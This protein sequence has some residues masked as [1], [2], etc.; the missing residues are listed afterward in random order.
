MLRNLLK[1]TNN[2]QASRYLK[3]HKCAAGENKHLYYLAAKDK[4]FYSVPDGGGGAAADEC[5]EQETILHGIIWSKHVAAVMSIEKTKK[6]MN[7]A[8]SKSLKASRCLALK[9]I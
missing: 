1:N 4:H 3:Q 5:S 2:K 8:K 6:R 9:T 7:E